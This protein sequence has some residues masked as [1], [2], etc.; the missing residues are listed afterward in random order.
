[1]TSD[2]QVPSVEM[3]VSRHYWLSSGNNVVMYER[4]IDFYS[5][6]CNQLLLVTCTTTPKFHQHSSTIF[7]L[8]ETHICIGHN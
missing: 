2:G 1:M 7:D 5:T 6:K 8:I 4:G 3:E